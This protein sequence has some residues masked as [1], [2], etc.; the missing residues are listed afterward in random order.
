MGSVDIGLQENMIMTIEPGY[1]AEGQF[2]IR[3]ENCNLI[4][5]ANTEFR[6]NGQKYLTFEP[7]TYVPIQREL[8]KKSIMTREEIVWLNNY[9]EKCR[10]C[11]CDHLQKANEKELYDW[12]I[13][14]TQPI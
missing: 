2:G 3:I 6:M 9:H 8:I 14:K 12:L 11:L 5:L 10:L 13:E 4:V 1:Y 7:L